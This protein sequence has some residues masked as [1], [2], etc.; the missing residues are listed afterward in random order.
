MNIY[1]PSM[2]HLLSQNPTTH[3]SLVARSPM[4]FGRCVKG[5]RKGALSEMVL[6]LGDTTLEAKDLVGGPGVGKGIFSEH[7]IWL[8]LQ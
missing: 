8:L 5:F 1:P 4:N 3:T 6:L 7:D 2:V